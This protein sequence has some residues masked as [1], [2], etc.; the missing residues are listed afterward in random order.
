MTL[1]KRKL[2]G[3]NVRSLRFV[4]ESQLKC[5]FSYHVWMIESVHQMNLSGQ[6]LFEEVLRCS[7]FVYRFNCYF[8]VVLFRVGELNFGVRAFP[9]G[10]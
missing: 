10:F 7:P 6:K 4:I 9:Q 3:I 2:S 5:N 1:A 8:F